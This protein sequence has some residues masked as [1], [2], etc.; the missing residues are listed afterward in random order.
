MVVVKFINLA[1]PPYVLYVKMLSFFVLF[2][3]VFCFFDVTCGV[4]CLSATEA[5]YYADELAGY[6]GLQV[7]SSPLNPDNSVHFSD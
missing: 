4:G 7:S 2:C 6:R 3:F 5:R 1:I